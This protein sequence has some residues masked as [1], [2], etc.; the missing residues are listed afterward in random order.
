MHEFSH[1]I[2]AKSLSIPIEKIKIGTEWPQFSMG[3]WRVS[4]IIGNSYVEVDYE[5]LIKLSKAK[6]VAFFMSGILMNILLAALFFVISS[7]AMTLTNKLV[8][9]INLILSI[10]NLLPLRHTDTLN[11]IAIMKEKH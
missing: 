4:P 5:S 10:L 7:Y 11:M 9:L 3:K 2:M 6:I 1:V 8:L